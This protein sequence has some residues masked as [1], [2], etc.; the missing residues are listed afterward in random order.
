M[1]PLTLPEWSSIV[2][3]AR[4]HV[5]IGAPSRTPPAAPRAPRRRLPEQHHQ[6]ASGRTL[7]HFRHLLPYAVNTSTSDSISYYLE[8]EASE[9]SGVFAGKELRQ[10]L[11]AWKRPEASAQGSR[12]R[13]GRRAHR[14]APLE[15]AR[16][17]ADKQG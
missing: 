9:V 12:H 13:D 5:K 10:T 16:P 3:R 6:G 7:G 2:L 15:T 11:P 17:A 4:G 8:S 1:P 14:A